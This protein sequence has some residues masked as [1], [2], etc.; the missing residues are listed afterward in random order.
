MPLKKRTYRKKT[1]YRKKPTATA[2][3]YKRRTKSSFQSSRVAS[4]PKPTSA[5]QRGVSIFPVS[6]YVR[7]KYAENSFITASGTT[8]LSTIGYT[9]SPNNTYDPRIQIGGKQPLEY[10]TMAGI[11]ERVWD[12]AAK[13]TLTFD[14]PTADGMYVGYRLRGPLNTTL[15]SGQNIDYLQTLQWTKMKPIN[16]TGKQQVS[17][18][19]YI[20]NHQVMGITKQ[21]YA[22]LEYSHT[23]TASPAAAN[24]FEPFAFHTVSGENATVRYNIKITFY[25]QFTNKSSPLES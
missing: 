14:N 22:N 18:S 25:S 3:P 4:L 16:N 5:V 24:F 9:Y 12:H 2:K 19:L 8:A 11:Y 6:Y 15:T 7:L 21:Q 23:T 20:P 1:T 13:I 17:F 10:D